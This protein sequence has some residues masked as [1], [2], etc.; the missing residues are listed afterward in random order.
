[1]RRR[2]HR[3]VLDQPVVKRPMI[4]EFQGTDRMA[5]PLDRIRLPMREI[6]G[7]VD[8][9]RVAGARMRAVQNAVEHRVAH[10]DVAGR[11]VDLRPE[12]PL[13]LGELPGPHAGEQVQAL[14]RR[15]VAIGAIPARLGQRAAILPHLV[16]RQIVDI[17]LARA[18]QMHRPVVKLLK[19]VRREIEMLAPIEAEPAHVRL[20]RVD[21]FVLFLGRIGVVEAQV[22][23]A[24]E[25]LRRARNSGR[26][27]WRVRYADS[28]SAPAETG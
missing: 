20:D 12:H 11:H 16:G 2:R 26:S 14:F 8:M 10:I 27:I 13:T 4:L 5:H 7:R 28:R 15:P 1:M 6:V 22:A 3:Q 25:L 21:I 9:P 24:A 23:A 19:I 17:G 18:D